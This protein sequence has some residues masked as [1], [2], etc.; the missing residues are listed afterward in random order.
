MIFDNCVF[1]EIHRCRYVLIGVIN[2]NRVL[3]RV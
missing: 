2:R 3:I 1:D